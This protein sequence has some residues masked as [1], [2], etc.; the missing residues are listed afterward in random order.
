MFIFLKEYLRILL[1]DS[2]I[3]RYSSIQSRKKHLTFWRVIWTFIWEFII[4]IL[5]DSWKSC[6]SWGLKKVHEKKNFF[7][8]I[9]CSPYWRILFLFS[10]LPKK[11]K[12]S[13][14]LFIFSV[15]LSLRF[16]SLEFLQHDL[17]KEI[18]IFFI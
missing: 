3:K 13:I 10:L 17:F 5:F 9:L 14:S 18:P 15:I 7:T 2:W 1:S 4:C 11:R 8:L 6:I 12:I 16:I